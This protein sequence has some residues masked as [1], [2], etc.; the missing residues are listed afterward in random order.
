MNFIENLKDYICSF[1]YTEDENTFDFYSYIYKTK[2]R[3]FNYDLIDQIDFDKTKT[4]DIVI[5]LNN[6]KYLYT[7]DSSYYENMYNINSTNK[8]IKLKYHLILCL[9]SPKD[10]TDIMIKHIMKYKGEKPIQI[11]EIIDEEYDK[12]EKRYLDLIKDTQD[13]DDDNDNQNN[14]DEDN[15]CKLSIK[16]KKVC[17]PSC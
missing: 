2:P 15:N 1:I 14:N 12:L 6:I 13:D 16:P 9:E 3:F 17:L 11:L 5:K 4:S 10:T 8:L 7:F